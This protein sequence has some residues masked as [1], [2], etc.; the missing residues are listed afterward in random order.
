MPLNSTTINIANSYVNINECRSFNTSLSTNLVALNSW[1]CSE[2]IFINKTGQQVLVFD[3]GYFDISN[4][5]LLENGESIV[6]RGLT[7]SS[8]VSARTVS[9]SGTIYYRTQN[10]SI[11]PQQ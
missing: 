6:L 2:V 9:G 1:P 3:S 4:S 10:Y 11:L 5:L 7:T 8:Q